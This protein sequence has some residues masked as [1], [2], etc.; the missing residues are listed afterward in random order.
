MLFF[1]RILSTVFSPQLMAKID[2]CVFKKRI[3]FSDFLDYTRIHDISVTFI[4]VRFFVELLLCMP[5]QNTRS[6]TYDRPAETSAYL[7][8]S[9]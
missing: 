7:S 8:A 5:E 6:S 9:T 3:Q 2:G 1:A 4:D